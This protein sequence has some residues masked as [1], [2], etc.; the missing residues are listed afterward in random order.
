MRQD[1]RGSLPPLPSGGCGSG[2]QPQACS[3]G[4]EPGASPAILAAGRQRTPPTST[5][6]CSTRSGA[7]P[8]V[9]RAMY[10]NDRLSRASPARMATSSPYTLWLVG[11]PRLRDRARRAR[12]AA[13][14]AA[15]F[16]P[17]P[18]MHAGWVQG[19]AYRRGA[20]G[21]LA[22]RASCVRV[23]TARDRGPGVPLPEANRRRPF[24]RLSGLSAPR[25]LRG[26]AGKAL[27]CQRQAG[28]PVG[29]TRRGPA[30]GEGGLTGSRRCPWRAGRRG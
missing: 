27:V 23:Q 8:R 13:G 3:S 25:M 24:L 28:P 4:A 15:A 2:T 12:A 17:V 14:E 10:S 7:T 30:A 26:Q 16:L 11:L 21:S 1:R 29:G 18:H 6:T 9:S 5:M 20:R 19:G 22:S